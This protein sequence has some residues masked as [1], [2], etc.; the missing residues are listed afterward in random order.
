MMLKSCWK[1]SR[2]PALVQVLRPNVW[3]RSFS[4]DSQ[5]APAAKLHNLLSAHLAPIEIPALGF[6]TWQLQGEKCRRAISAALRAGYRHIDTA[7]VY[8]NEEVIGQVL[9]QAFGNPPKAVSPPVTTSDSASAAVPSTETT[10]ASLPSS[11]QEPPLPSLKRSDVWITS[12]LWNTH[13]EQ[14]HV[15]EACEESL[16]KLGVEQLDLYL[17][18]W[19]VAFSY[20]A[21]G[22]RY[23][24]GGKSIPIP[25]HETWHAMEKLVQKGLTRYIG[26][27]NFGITQIA[28]LLR[29]PK[30]IV[31]PAVNQF[32]LHPFLSQSKLIAYCQKKGI[33]VQGYSPLGGSKPTENLSLLNNSIVKEIAESHSTQP[34]AV[35]LRWQL[36]QGF[37][38]LPRSQSE[39]HILHNFQSVMNFSLSQA[40]MDKLASLNVNHRF[41]VPSWYSFE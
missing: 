16:R 20:N 8:E 40:D 29:H 2:T 28:E 7:A 5:P 30:T 10:P 11:A 38:T 35:L 13:H 39:L 19:P 21:E 36:Q 14:E 24:Q 1:L 18:H 23:P 33:L 34:S 12:K 15:Q 3:D 41:I 25:L 22:E 4:S 6:G 32:E 31:R 26:V 17:M 9:A 37:S 27:S